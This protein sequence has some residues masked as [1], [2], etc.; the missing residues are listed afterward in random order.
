MKFRAMGAELLRADRRTYMT[1]VTVT[2]LNFPNL[3]TKVTFTMT[4][5]N[6]STFIIYKNN[7]KKN[8]LR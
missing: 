8:S 2:F 4:V 7:T 6:T 3:P 1:E 5:K